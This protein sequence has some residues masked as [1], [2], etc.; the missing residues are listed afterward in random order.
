MQLG[1]IERARRKA[2]HLFGAPSVSMPLYEGMISITFDDFPH[3]AWSEGGA[4]LASHGVKG[5]YYV[6]GR[7]CGS[8][9]DGQEQFWESD[10]AALSEAGHE[11]GCHTFDHIS[12]LK[13]SARSFARSIEANARF[14]SER[15]GGRK[16]TSFAYPYGD[17]SLGALSTVAANYTSGRLVVGD[18]NKS[19]LRPLLLGA[20]AFESARPEADRWEQVV[21]QAAAERQWLVIM[22]HDVQDRPS[23]YGCTPKAL[24]ALLTAARKAGLR[25]APVDDV[26]RAGGVGQDTSREA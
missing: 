5:T 13:T 9:M 7:L 14:L 23:A 24:D 3:T 25:A 11:V 21:E 22:T 20:L 8:E 4:V 19:I 15:L 6:S 18:C 16:A 12:A 1:V 10:L 26:M 2:A 17:V